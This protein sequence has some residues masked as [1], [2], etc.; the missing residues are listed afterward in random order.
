[1]SLKR[2]ALIVFEGCDRVGKSTQVSHLLDALH[3]QGHSAQLYKFPNRST[4]IGQLIDKFLKSQQS[5]DDRAIHLLFSANRW[6]CV[7]EML[8]KLKSGT[9][10]LVDRY[11]YSGIVY[12]ASKPVR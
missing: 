9:T 3:S 7:D 8:H 5:M 6:E 2:G 10:L 12:S 11:A 1:M 4:V